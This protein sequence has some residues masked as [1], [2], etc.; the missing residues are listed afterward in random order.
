MA[1]HWYRRCIKLTE[2]TGIELRRQKTVIFSKIC[3]VALTF[4]K[5][6]SEK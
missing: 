6:L 1:A 4:F 5:P 2:P 3:V